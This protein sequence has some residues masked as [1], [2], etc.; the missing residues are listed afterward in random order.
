MIWKKPKNVTR[1][2]VALTI[3]SLQR[4]V[5]SLERPYR[6][7]FTELGNTLCKGA[8]Q[9]NGTH[10]A[11]TNAASESRRS[12]WWTTALEGAHLSVY[13]VWC[14][15]CSIRSFLFQNVYESV[16][17]L[18]PVLE[19]GCA[20]LHPDKY[21]YSFMCPIARILRCKVIGCTLITPL[22]VWI[23]LSSSLLE[24]CG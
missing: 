18:F 19:A 9:A 7:T 17:F 15:G 12:M 22:L 3:L 20:S 11:L 14:G 23:A 2:E 13:F 6:G 10:Q 5:E 8:L 4:R 16:D 1:M 24:Y 21:R